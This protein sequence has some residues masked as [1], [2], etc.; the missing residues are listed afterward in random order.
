MQ[1]VTPPMLCACGVFDARGI[2][3]WGTMRSEWSES[4]PWRDASAST[5]R[6]ASLVGR[7]EQPRLAAA[8]LQ[9]DG[10]V[11]GG[12]RGA[13]RSRLARE[14]AA[15]ARTS[16]RCVD[17]VA[18]SRSAAGIPLAAL[19]SLLADGREGPP[20]TVGQAVAALAARSEATREW[21]LACDDAHLLDA[22]SAVVM[23]QFATRGKVSLLLTV[24]DE[25]Q[26]PE[27]V[28]ALWRDELLA[29]VDLPQPSKDLVSTTLRDVLGA[30]LDGIS[31]ERIY[32]LC[33][34][35]LVYLRELVAA[36]DRDDGWERIGAAGR[37]NGPLSL[38]ARLDELVW[39]RLAALTAAEHTVLELLAWRA[40]ERS[41]CANSRPAR[42]WSP[43][44]A[45][46]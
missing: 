17:W 14:L 27:P 20:R 11:I 42:T 15:I 31:L 28:T 16:D 45:K 1:C 23:R 12:P 40:W 29:R 24:C 10:V 44:R 22:E 38:S 4:S 32:R 7:G 6:P 46:G 25:E 30:P 9:R 34:G 35:N 43:W 36:V 2:R 41:C 21:V 3:E 18:T 13:G 39:S 33:E 5:R 26:C 8:A 19:S 37:W